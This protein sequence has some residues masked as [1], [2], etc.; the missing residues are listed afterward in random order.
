M[1]FLI[2]REIFDNRLDNFATELKFISRL[3]NHYSEA[4]TGEA[5][6]AELEQLSSSIPAVALMADLIVLS[7]LATVVNKF[8]NAWI[9]IEKIRILR[10]QLEEI[11]MGGTAT[12]QLD[13]RIT[14]TIDQVV[15]ESTQIVLAPYKGDT[16]RRSELDTAVRQDTRRL[17]GQIERG[18][19]VEF[20]TGEP[21]TDA[22][23]EKQKALANIADLDKKMQFPPVV[24]EPMLLGT[25]EVLEGEIKVSHSKKTTSHK[26]TTKETF[27]RP[28]RKITLP[29]TDGDEE[30][31]KEE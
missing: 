5:K 16:G 29:P 30:N 26:A 18:L 10:S 25:G 3:V 14:T 12:D 27:T 31:G 20:R 1:A 28:R 4:L 24:T 9:K 13:E 2:P 8:L 7:T 21:K 22:D 6:P 23:P 15:E 11:G 17:F 19:M